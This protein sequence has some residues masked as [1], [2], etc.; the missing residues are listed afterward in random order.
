MSFAKS[1]DCPKLAP[2]APD[3]CPSFMNINPLPSAR[4]I[5]SRP[6][7]LAAYASTYLALLSLPASCS[8]FAT[9]SNVI[10]D[11]AYF[12]T[13]ASNSLLPPACGAAVLASNFSYALLPSINFCA[14]SSAACKSNVFPSESLIFVT[15]KLL[16][17]LK[18]TKPPVLLNPRAGASV[19]IS[20]YDRILFMLTSYG[21]FCVFICT[22]IF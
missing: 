7:V 8:I 2:L 10:P 9:S 17:T 14:S 16:S 21:A 11:F 5:P 13:I 19:K 15:G 1:C 12:A 3:G 18:F 4:Y 22:N 6:S 20:K